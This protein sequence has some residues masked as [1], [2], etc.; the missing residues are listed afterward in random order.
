MSN[1]VN[2]LWD[3]QCNNNMSKH[4]I[5]KVI[6]LLKVKVEITASGADGDKGSF[7]EVTSL[8]RSKSPFGEGV[9]HNAHTKANESH[10]R[11]RDSTIGHLRV[12]TKPV[13]METLGA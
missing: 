11:H 8:A 1:K 12:V 5:N 3:K 4:K 10:P 6:S 2:N 9:Q 13:E 7:T